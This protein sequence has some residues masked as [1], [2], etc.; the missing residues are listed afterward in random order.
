MNSLLLVLN[1]SEPYRV[2]IAIGISLK[3]IVRAGRRFE[4][5]NVLRV[6][7]RRNQLEHASLPR[8][9]TLFPGGKPGRIDVQVG[10]AVSRKFNLH[11]KIARPRCLDIEVA[12]KNRSEKMD[13]RRRREKPCESLTSSPPQHCSLPRQAPP[14]VT[15]TRKFRRV[16][17]AFCLRR[18]N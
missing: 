14:R 1:R 15:R 12:G 17:P 10:P 13:F 2:F 6:P 9:A 4:T 7:V 18:S 11:N 5:A 8:F 3:R 16:L